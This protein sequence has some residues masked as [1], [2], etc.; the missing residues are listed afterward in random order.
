MPILYSLSIGAVI[1]AVIHNRAIVVTKI[2]DVT[3]GLIDAYH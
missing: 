1:W 3:R 2:K